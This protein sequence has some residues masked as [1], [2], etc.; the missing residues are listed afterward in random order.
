MKAETQSG[1]TR[2]RFAFFLEA[3]EE[4]GKFK[5]FVFWVFFI[6]SEKTLTLK[7]KLYPITQGNNLC[8]NFK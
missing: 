5:F 6:V 3:F 1:E 2:Q 7:R 8:L 4:V